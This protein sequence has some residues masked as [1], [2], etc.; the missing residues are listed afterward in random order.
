MKLNYTEDE[1]EF[2]VSIPP[3]PS[4]VIY[5]DF[6]VDE[7][8]EAG[9]E[10]LGWACVAG[11][12]F[13]YMPIIVGISS[14]AS[15]HTLSA[16]VPAFAYLIEEQP[17]IA[18][19]WDGL[20]GAMALTLMVSFLPTFLVIIFY[21]FFALKAEAWLQHKVQL[22]YYYFNVIFVLLVT[23]VG[24][25]LLKTVDELIKDPTSIFHLLA[26]TM[27]TATHF[28][29]NLYPTQWATHSMILTRYV[30][31]G[32]YKMFET[33]HRDESDDNKRGKIAHDL[34]EPEDQDYY[35][36]GSRSAR[37]TIMLVIGVVFCTLSPLMLVL[38]FINFALCRAAYGY[39]FLYAE[40]VKA[41]LGG[42]F[43]VSQLKHVQQCL[44][45][46]ITL[47]AGVLFYRGYDA[48]GNGP[49]GAPGI[50]AGGAFLYAIPMYNKFDR[51]FHWVDL[52]YEIVSRDD[53][54]S[55]NKRAARRGTYQQP[56]LMEHKSG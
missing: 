27:P 53:E 45:I 56:E 21:R 3:D 2:R 49:G 41:D 13:G 23:A 55:E 6:M 50:I 54:K 32:K 22:W 5:R 46:Y 16:H 9:S 20:V 40:I 31:W 51:K 26:D 52:P 30:Q 36:M 28:Y 17:S 8:T 18:A 1:D 12:F 25:S 43:F 4:D 11:L 15:L 19:I 24:S 29:L 14:V 10:L 47:M 39:L 34:A 44:F 37:F 33:L 48:D 7:T 35:G 42:P 38:A